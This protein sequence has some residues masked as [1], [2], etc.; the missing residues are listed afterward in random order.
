MKNGFRIMDSDIHL[1]EPPDMYERYLEDRFVPDAPE[2]LPLEGRVYGSWLL[3]MPGQKER[4]PQTIRSMTA[5]GPRVQ[6]F[7]PLIKDALED[8]YGPASTLRAMDVEGVDVAVAF[9]TF[10]RGQ[11]TIDDLDPEYA[12]A[13][14][15]AYN[16]FLA[17]FCKLDLERLKGVALVSLHDVG[18]AAAEAR[19]AVAELGMVGLTLAPNPIGE[20]YFHD[21]ECDPLWEAAQELNVPICLHD[22]N[23]GWNRGHLANF[24]RY[25]PSSTTL[26]QT[27]GFPLSLMEALGSF[28]I[29]GVLERFPRLRLALL[30]GNCSWLPWLLWRLEEQ[31]EMYKERESVRL[32]LRPTEYF[33]RQ[34]Y[35]SVEPSEGPA[36]YAVDA[37]GDGNLVI[38]TDYPHPDS[39]YPH[40]MD[41]FLALDQVGDDSKRKVLWDNCA[42]LYDL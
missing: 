26:T 35:A 34:C 38:S 8:G 19:R 16:S 12:A 15:R 37:L 20:R 11:V 27:F 13:L 5:A 17:D 23:A 21:P 6:R 18:L 2:Y 7:M 42:R 4:I 30:E 25:H 9:P 39:S 41:N 28:I 14:C 31:W 33:L 40:S 24:L 29:G 1:M 36:K 3:K 10:A 32:S 22:T